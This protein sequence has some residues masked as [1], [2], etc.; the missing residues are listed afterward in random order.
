M[1]VEGTA[2]IHL[3]DVYLDLAWLAESCSIGSR[4]KDT[5]LKEVTC[6]FEV[7]CTCTCT[8]ECMCVPYIFHSVNVYPGGKVHSKPRGK[9]QPGGIMHKFACSYSPP[10]KTRIRAHVLDA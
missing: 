9:Y 8:Y 6:Q 2:C 7:T 4:R 5:L 1:H 10:D 3:L